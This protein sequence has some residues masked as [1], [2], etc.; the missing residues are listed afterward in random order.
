M[1]QVAAGGTEHGPW[2]W[3]VENKHL[4]LEALCARM[5]PLWPVVTLKLIRET[6]ENRR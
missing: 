2:P 6:D 5:A 1:D 3:R 4:K